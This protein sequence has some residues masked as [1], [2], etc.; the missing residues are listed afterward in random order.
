MDTV[1]HAVR[2]TTGW[3]TGVPIVSAAAGEVAGE[4]LDLAISSADEL[5]VAYQ[6]WDTTT[7]TGRLDVVLADAGGAWTGPYLVDDGVDAGSTDVGAYVSVALDSGGLP[8]F[9][10]L[11]YT[12]GSPVLADFSSW[13]VAVYTPA[14]LPVLGVT[15][16]YTSLAIDSAD[17]DHIAYYDSEDL[18]V[19]PDAVQYTALGTDYESLV[20]S[21][22]IADAGYFTSV[23]LRSDD[24]PC[25]AWQDAANADLMYACRTGGSW[26]VETVESAGSVGAWARL[27]HNSADEP[28]IAY[29]D[30]TH[31]DL[32]VAHLRDGV[33]STF[34]V[35]TEG[36]VGTGL[37]LAIDAW[38]AVHIVYLDAT[39][40]EL[41]YAVG[42]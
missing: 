33:W 21:E 19:V 41:R 22:T 5:I 27:A 9:A 13:G 29:Y 8:S 18:Y 31:G 30:E 39:T 23:S 4:F 17:R 25:V 38:D 14:D 6:V 3:S 42:E 36:D 15:G 16:Y 12:N 11:D 34:T 1:H 2:S 26:A 7:T 28:Y 40:G 32:E 37:D 20:W 24:T 10:Y 35:D